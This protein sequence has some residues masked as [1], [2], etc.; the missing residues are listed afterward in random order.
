MN[1]TKEGKGKSRFVFLILLLALMLFP[2]TTAQASEQ[3]QVGKQYESI[4]LIGTCFNN[5]TY[6]SSQ[7]ICNSTIIDPRGVVVLDN[8]LETNQVAFYN[9]TLSAANTGEI[10]EYTQSRTCYDP[11]GDV[12]GSGFEEKPFLIT[13]S[14]SDANSLSNLILMGMAL[15][16]SGGVIIFGFSKS[17]PYIVI[18]GS[19]VLVLL[20]LFTLLNGIG[21]YRNEL[22]QWSSIIISLIGGYISVRSGLE[23]MDVI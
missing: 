1:S 17:E 5:G 13:P 22:T 10:G 18:L 4:N 20:G 2:F 23:V 6:C 21:N 19:F 8:A 14:G 3:I 11:A 15:I 16:L 7:T 9:I 12:T